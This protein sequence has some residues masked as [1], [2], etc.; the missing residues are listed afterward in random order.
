M[1]NV[2]P[3]FISKEIEDGIGD[4]RRRRE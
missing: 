1:K 4:N 2:K 3:Y